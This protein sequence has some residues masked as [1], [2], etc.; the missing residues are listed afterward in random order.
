MA[1][2][3][4]K[5]SAGKSIFSSPVA[6]RSTVE[7]KKVVTKNFIMFISLFAVS[8]I[9]WKVISAEFWNNLFFLLVLVFGFVSLAFFIVWMILL[10]LKAKG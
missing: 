10:M 1:K 9:L 3:R 8:Y 6:L 5:K 2:R 4:V 7:K